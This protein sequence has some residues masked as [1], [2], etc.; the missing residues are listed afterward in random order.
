[1][2]IICI[3]LLA[4]ITTGCAGKEDK[5]A[6]RQDQ[7]RIVEYIKEKVELDNKEKIKIIKFGKCKKMFLWE[8][9]DIM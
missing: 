1:M 4:V 2:S 9:G 8:L 3:I 5:E 6:I 7:D